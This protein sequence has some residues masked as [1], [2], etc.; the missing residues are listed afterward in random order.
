MRA[1]FVDPPSPPGF[2]AFRDAHGGLGEM[3]LK[4]RLRV[5]TLDVFHSAAWALRS[6]ARAAVVDA[7]ARDLTPARALAEVAALRPRL[8]AVRTASGSA[9]SDL[10]FG[11][12]AK[13][14]TGAALVFFGPQAALERAE[15]L[16]AGADGVV[17]GDAPPV[18]GA[19]AAA[20]RL[21]PMRGLSLPG[22]P[23]PPPSRL[24]D[25]D[26]LPVPRWDL[27][28]RRPYSHVVSQTAWGC[29]VGC[30]YCPYPVTQGARVRA[31]SAASVVAELKSL[32][33]WGVPYVLFRDPFF[34]VDR[35]RTLALCAA[36]EAAGT[37]LL[38]GCE[39]RPEALDEELVAAMARAGCIRVQFGVESAS[40]SVLR[41]AGR[42]PLAPPR[43]R[44]AVA[45]LKRHRMLTHAMYI[46]GLP[47][48]TEAQGRATLELSRALGTDSAAF[49][50][51]T[52]FPG[53][54]L[55]RDA[56]AAGLV[57]APD[58]R[59]LTA[60]LPSMSSGP[61]PAEAVG[62]LRQ[63]AKRLWK[64]PRRTREEDHA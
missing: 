38:W 22:R 28:D 52:P 60:A 62:R 23:A 7:A 44:A 33:A 32:R 4:S 3:C 15:L 10:A 64:R 11:L 47:G 31:R 30:G 59:R 46:V 35:R 13:A 19:V 51:A 37:P 45:L 40:P 17:L 8:L 63:E 24:S 43:L 36:V 29:P 34:T 14:A 12:K 9:A 61:M 50:C 18:F 20:G 26:R 6:G 41:A 57:T 21:A 58:P 1:A 48:E 16:A 27:L 49:S 42:T 54:R 25:V 55:E 53:T 56:R 39:T 2:V 5:P